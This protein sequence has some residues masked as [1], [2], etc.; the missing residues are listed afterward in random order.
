MERNN[1]ETA[2]SRTFSLT[3]CH[4][5]LRHLM[6]ERALFILIDFLADM[7]NVFLETDRQ[8]RSEQVQA[9]LHRHQRLVRN[10]RVFAVLEDAEVFDTLNERHKS[11]VSTAKVADV[12]LTALAEC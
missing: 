10:S 3:T 8:L 4:A 12:I 1:G 7:K 6:V 9:L 5:I 11:Y 2:E